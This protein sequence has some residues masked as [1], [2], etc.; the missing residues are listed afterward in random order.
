M[1]SK[2]LTP[3]PRQPVNRLPIG[4]LAIEQSASV[5][6]HLAASEYGLRSEALAAYDGDEE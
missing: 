5:A 2:T 6:A 1:N 3:T 4:Q